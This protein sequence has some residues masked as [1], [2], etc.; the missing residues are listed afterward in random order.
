MTICDIVGKPDKFPYQLTRLTLGEKQNS[1][2]WESDN[3]AGNR[4][5]RALKIFQ[6]IRLKVLRRISP[7]KSGTLN[8][9]CILIGYKIRTVLLPWQ[10]GLPRSL[11]ARPLWRKEHNSKVVQNSTLIDIIES[12]KY[13]VALAVL[14]TH[15]Y[16]AKYI[17]HLT[18]NITPLL[19]KKL[20]LQIL[21]IMTGTRLLAF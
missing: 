15:V 11:T 2:G 14:R 8:I 18:H 7:E 5:T 17:F 10:L 19:T 16:T 6:E 4:E 1:S 12:S 21:S 13:A 20:D 9:I 3:F